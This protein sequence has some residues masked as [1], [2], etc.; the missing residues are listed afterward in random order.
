MVQSIKLMH[1]QD[2]KIIRF[3]HYILK[4]QVPTGFALGH[5]IMPK[6]NELNAIVCA[7]GIESYTHASAYHTPYSI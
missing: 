2:P 5:G 4:I 7:C 3:E 6:T 1:R